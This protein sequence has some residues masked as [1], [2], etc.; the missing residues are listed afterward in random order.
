M[1]PMDPGCVL[2]LSDR[3]YQV[4]IRVCVSS[5]LPLVVL[6][7]PEDKESVIEVPQQE[8]ASSKESTD[9]LVKAFESYLDDLRSKDAVLTEDAALAVLKASLARSRDSN[10]PSSSPPLGGGTDAGSVP[11]TSESGSSGSQ[12]SQQPEQTPPSG[13]SNPETGD[14]V[15]PSGVPASQASE[16]IPLSEGSVPKPDKPADPPISYLPVPIKK[17]TWIFSSTRMKPS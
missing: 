4:Q 9:A 15:A 3:A 2:Y 5:D 16:D 11:G 10:V 12:I 8:Q 1:D 14:V 13:G 17:D 6:A 7:R